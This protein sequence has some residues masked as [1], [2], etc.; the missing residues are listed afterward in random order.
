M[1]KVLVDHFEE[2]YEIALRGY[3]LEEPEGKGS[4]MNRH[5]EEFL[6]DQS[7][8]ELYKQLYATHKPIKAKFTKEHLE[9]IGLIIV[10]F[11]RLEYTIQDSLGWLLDIQ[12]RQRMTRI[13]T[14]KMSFRNL[15]STMKALLKEVKFQRPLDLELLL[16]KALAAEDIRNQMV[17]SLWTSNHRLKSDLSKDGFINVEDHSPDE[18]IAIAT[19]IDQ[20]DTAIDAIIFEYL[21]YRCDNGDPPK[22][23]VVINS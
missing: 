1:L 15:I 5:T 13:I 23:F 18:L 12:N 7:F 6:N 16:N 14:A 9:A 4:N 21:V 3:P 11:Q 20:L 10:K 8:C 2:D 22:G 17:H 19:T